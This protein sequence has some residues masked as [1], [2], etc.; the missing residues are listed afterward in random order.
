MKHT[1]TL[2][3]YLLKLGIT[4]EQS[5]VYLKLTQVGPTTALQLAR[6]TGFSRTQVYRYLEDL[7]AAALVSQEKLS[8][9]TL[10]RA[11]S[12]DGLEGLIASREAELSSLKQGLPDVLKMLQFMAGSH[13]KKTTVHHFYGLAGLKQVN[14][15][16]TKAHKEF[17]VFEK[18]HITQHLDKSFGRRTRERIIERKIATYDLTNE[19][20]HFLVDLEPIDLSRSVIR[21]IDPK[22]LQIQFEMYIYNDIITLLDYSE[23]NNIAIEIRNQSLNDMIT[24][25]YESMWTS[26]E[27]VVIK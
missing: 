26:G 21:Y 1:K 25:I 18:K 15:N 22:I 7:S 13:G 27:E 17:R 14:W 9:G 20:N 11:L 3:R 4:P 12:I 24:Q 23:D 19:K 8:Y 2:Q 6:D 5:L 10:F 16:L